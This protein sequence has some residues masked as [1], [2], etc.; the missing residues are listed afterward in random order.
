MVSAAGTGFLSAARRGARRGSHAVLRLRQV[1]PPDPFQRRRQRTGRLA[2]A[3]L[4][5][6]AGLQSLRSASTGLILLPCVA[7]TAEAM[8]AMV[9]RMA[10]TTATVRGSRAAVSNNSGSRRGPARVRRPPR[11]SCR[12]IPILQPA[13]RSCQRSHAPLRQGLCASRSPCVAEQRRRRLRCTVQ[14]Q[15]SIGLESR[16]RGTL[17]RRAAMAAPA[18]RSEHAAG[19]MVSQEIPGCSACSVRRSSGIAASASPRGRMTICAP[20]TPRSRPRGT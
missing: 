6:P 19:L 12:P 7:G 2:V 8:K 11:W 18:A 14:Q 10:H 16:K 5:A 3:L 9:R 17:S 13:V 1:K 4:R 20:P 15:R